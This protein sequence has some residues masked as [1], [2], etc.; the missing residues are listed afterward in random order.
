MKRIAIMQPYFFPYL[1]YWQLI[2]S[3]D[4]FI[5]LDDVNF[6]KKGWIH[7]NNI[8]SNGTTQS[9][10]VC[11]NKASQNKLIKDLYLS[12]EHDW[13]D[14]LIKK[15]EY[16]YRTSPNYNSVSFLLE[17]I[18]FN[19]EKNLSKY[20]AYS[21]KKICEYL[22][23][24][25]EIVESSSKYFKGQLKGQERIISICSEEKADIYINAIGGKSLYSK[26]DFKKNQIFLTFIE[27]SNSPSIIDF[28][29]NKEK[30]QINNLLNA[31]R[32]TI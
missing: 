31:Y 4:K 2:N 29:V 26:K 9:I 15:I 13:K 28:L 8:I 30:E 24:S 25:T 3:V 22:N 17:D 7:K 23:I 18:I 10:N 21:I 20:L 6:I 14:K 11:V 16:A 5:I 1:G 12:D 32:L 27:G 19:K